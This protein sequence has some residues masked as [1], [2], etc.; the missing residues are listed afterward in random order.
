MRPNAVVGRLS[1]LGHDLRLL[2]RVED[3]LAQELVLKLAI[4]AL[5]MLVLPRRSWSDVLDLRAGFGD[6]LAQ[7]LRDHLRAIVAADVL[8]DAMQAHR[9]G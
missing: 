8:W 6:S 5:I 9:V 2:Q 4:E 3:F 1:E 7:R